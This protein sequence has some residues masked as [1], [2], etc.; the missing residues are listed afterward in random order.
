[1][2]FYGNLQEEYLQLK[3]QRKASQ[4]GRYLRSAIK[5][6]RELKWFPGMSIMV[7]R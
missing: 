7:C 1:M 2:G 4:K 6:V 3:R 5:D